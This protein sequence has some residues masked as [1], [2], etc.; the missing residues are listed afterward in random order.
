M[1]RKVNLLLLS[2]ILLEVFLPAFTSAEEVLL[3][4]LDYGFATITYYRTGEN[5]LKVLV[6][7][8]KGD[9][10][11]IIA[12]DVVPPTEEE[13]KVS[14]RLVESKWALLVLANVLVFYHFPANVT[15][16]VRLEFDYIGKGEG[17]YE[18]P[19]TVFTIRIPPWYA[20][21]NPLFVANAFA[22]ILFGTSLYGSQYYVTVPLTTI[23]RKSIVSILFSEEDYRRMYEE[24]LSEYTKICSE[25][26]ILQSNY[27]K[28]KEE[29]N[30]MKNEYEEKIKGLNERVVELEIELSEVVEREQIMKREIEEQVRSKNFLLIALA[31][32]LIGY[33]IL[34]LLLSSKR[35]AKKE[36]R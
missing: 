17:L 30:K 27:T 14:M 24:L 11:E 22:I 8:E 36:K 31:I 25:Y 5:T 3:G 35:R 13:F 20:S 32:S 33:P 1:M 7:I 23:G 28:L 16:Y 6:K 2:L 34:F 29:Y 4:E 26:M 19:P 18:N 21:T 12:P 9:V 15:P 10:V